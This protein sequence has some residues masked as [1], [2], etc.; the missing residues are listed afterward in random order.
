M[1]E[2]RIKIIL[3]EDNESDAVLIQRQ[4]TKIVAF[5]L[6][7]HVSDFQQLQDSLDEFQP[8]LILCDYQLS[9]FTGLEV[10]KYISS[11][12]KYIPIIF[13][14]GT[15]N[16]EEL[17][18]NTILTGASGYILKK[19][20]NILHEKLLPH[21]TKIIKAKE[22]ITISEEHLA[23]FKEMK[24]YLNFIEAGQ[25]IKRANFV[26]IKRALEKIKLLHR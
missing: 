2:N 12:S 24:E 1:V 5:P 18:A 6:V 13:I 4:I 15:I 7:I 10:L 16:D 14:T 22:D 25:T 21:L 23:V 26:E 20:I 8:D 19:N 9:G 17:A 3:V 11:L